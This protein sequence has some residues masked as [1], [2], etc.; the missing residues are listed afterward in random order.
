MLARNLIAAAG[1]AGGGVS[2]WIDEWV[3]SNTNNYITRVAVNSNRSSILFVAMNDAGSGGYPYYIELDYDGNPIRKSY[4]SPTTGLSNSY[5]L[6]VFPYGSDYVVVHQNTY[7]GA[8]LWTL[9]LVDETSSTNLREAYNQTYNNTAP[10]PSATPT[11]QDGSYQPGTQRIYANDSYIA[12]FDGGG[13]S[14]Y[15]A[16]DYQ[17][18]VGAAKMTY[19]GVGLT[20]GSTNGFITNSGWYEPYDDTR[21]AQ[22]SSPYGS[23]Y[24]LIRWWLYSY[25]SNFYSTWNASTGAVSTPKRVSGANFNSGIKLCI[26]PTNGYLY[27][28]TNSNGVTCVIYYQTTGNVNT[29][30]YPDTLRNISWNTVTASTTGVIIDAA[31]DSDGNMYL[32]WGRG[33]IMKIS[34]SFTVVWAASITDS[35]ASYVSPANLEYINSIRIE[36]VDGT[37]VMFVTLRLNAKSGQT[38]KNIQIHK[39]PLDLDNYYGTYGN[40]TYA[41]VNSSYVTIGSATAVTTYTSPMYSATGPSNNLTGNLAGPTNMTE[42]TWTVNQQSI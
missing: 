15:Y 18:V 6:D 1:N 8:Y 41:A 27:D 40:V 17:T 35:T 38:T 32:L 2:Y 33:Y 42:Q 39:L 19:S 25:N 37:E 23:N 22:I 13:D 11:Y 21:R 31:I 5:L 24:H 16:P 12:K 36:D 4:F 26:N 34:S 3:P 20:S 30:Y 28:I 14:F 7:S 9:G 10:T 29:Y